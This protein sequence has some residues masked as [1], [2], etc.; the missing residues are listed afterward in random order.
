MLSAAYSLPARSN[1]RMRVS[2]RQLRTTLVV[3]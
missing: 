2:F 3:R 1:E